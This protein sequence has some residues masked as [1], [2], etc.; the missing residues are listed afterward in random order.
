MKIVDLCNELDYEKKLVKESLSKML[1]LYDQ[2]YAIV[3][4]NDD[5]VIL[6]KIKSGRA[7]I[8]ALLRGIGD[9]SRIN[10]I[11]RSVDPSKY[12]DAR[13]NDIS[14]R[15]TDVIASVMKD[16]M[17]KAN[18]KKNP[19]SPKSNEVDSDGE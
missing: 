18:N 9:I 16:R 14:D 8:R 11:L 12:Y 4:S 5:P 2:A 17:K 10:P 1:E 15:V 3:E 7:R 6:L 13:G 19:I